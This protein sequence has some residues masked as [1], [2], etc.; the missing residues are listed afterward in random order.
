MKRALRNKKLI[1]MMVVG[2]VAVF[3][4]GNGLIAGTPLDTGY[5][6]VES[7][8]CQGQLADGALITAVEGERIEDCSAK[9]EVSLTTS[10]TLDQAQEGTNYAFWFEQTVIRWQEFRPTQT[11]LAKIDLYIDKNGNPGNLL[12]SVKDQ[13]EDVLWDAAVPQ[14]DIGESGWLEIPVDPSILLEPGSSYYI[15]VWSDADSPSP[16]QRCFWRGQTE[17]DY[18]RGISSQ[19]SGLPGYDFA[20]RTWTSLPSCVD[21]EDP[22]LGTEYYV[23]DTFADSGAVITVQSFQWSDGQWYDGGHTTVGNYGDAGGSG[24]EMWLNNVNLGFDFGDPWEGLSVLFGY[25]GGNLNIDINGDF[26][27]FNTFID[28]N[29][30]TIG[31]VNVVANDFG[32]GLGRLDL[33]GKVNSFAIGGQELAIDDVCPAVPRPVIYFADGNEIPGSVYRLENGMES[34]FYTRSSGR[35]HNLAFSPQGTLYYSNAND[36]DLYKLAGGETLVYHHDTYLGDVAFDSLGR[37]YFSEA[38]GAGGDGYIYRLDGETAFLYYTVELADVSFWGG[39]FTFDKDDNLYLSSGNLAGAKIYE[40]LD[41]IPG[42]VFSAPGQPITGIS[43][44]ADGSLFYAGWSG[45]DIYKVDLSAGERELFYSNP[46]HVHLSDVFV[47]GLPVEPKPDLIVESITGPASAVLG[48][49]LGDSLTLIIKN[50]GTA[51]AVGTGGY[52]NTDLV[53]SSDAVIGNGDDILLIGGRDQVFDVLASGQSLQVTLAGSN[54]IPEGMTTGLYYL[55]AIVDSFGSRVVESDEDNNTN[56]YYPIEIQSPAPLYLSLN[57]EDALEGIPVN[58]VV[59]DTDGPTY[60]TRLEIV[61][62]LS[63]W[64]SSAKDNIPVVLTIPDNIFGAPINTWVRD[65]NGGAL[66]AVS[67]DNLGDGQYR[68]TT[69]LSPFRTTFRKQI[70]WRFLIPNELPPQDVTVNAEIQVPCVDPFGTGTVRILAPGSVRTLIIAN[71]KLLYD[72]Y[73]EYQVT[74]LLQRLFTEAQGYPA[75][76]TPRAVIYYVE[77][78]D[79]RAYN[80]DNTAVDYTSEA[81]ANVAADAID[82]LIED[83]H[84]DAT[85]YVEIYIP[86]YGYAYLPIASPSFLLIVGDD[87]TI[88]FY[89]YDDPSNDEGINVRS[90]CPAAQGWCVDSA[91]NPAVH[92]TDED[93]I[94]TDNPYADLW[95]GTDWQTGS[96]ELYAGRLLGET[97]ADMLSLLE[98]GVSWDNGDRGGVVMASVDGWELG[99]EHDPG[100]AGHITD[101]YDVP[102]L[103]RGKG[104]VVRN[105]DIPAGEVQTIDVMSPY[106]GGSNSWNTNFRNAANSASG[107]DLFFIGGHD[108]YDHAVIPGDNFSPDDTC[109]GGTCDYNRFDDDHPIAMIVGCHGGLP[110][111]DGGG[112]NGGVDNDM[113]YDLVHEGVSAYIG[114][115]GF[116]YGSPSNLH[117]C[118]WAERLIQRFF[119]QLLMPSGGNSMALGAALAKA[120]SG[121]VFGYGGDDSLDR[122]TVT[123]FNLYGVPWTFIYYPSA[124]TATATGETGK[125]SFAAEAGAIALVDDGV[126]SRMFEVGIDSYDVATETQDDTDYDLFSIEGGDI[127]IADGAPILPYV[128]GYKMPLP[129]GATVTNVEVLDYT[130]SYIGTYNVPIALVAPWSEEGLRYTTETD[131]G[132]PYPAD[133]DLVQYQQNG[134]GLLFTIFPIQHNP[135]TDET[136]FYSHFEIQIT[137]ESPLAVVVTEFTTNK[138]QYVPGEEINTTADIANVGDVDAA[139]TATLTI[140][141]ALGETL[142]IETAG[143]FIVP[144]GGSHALPLALGGML[145]DGDY[146][147]EITVES[148]QAIVGGASTSISVIGGEITDLVVPEVLPLGE[149]GIFQVTFANYGDSTVTGEVTMTIQASDGG[150]T[151]ELAPQRI[152]VAGGSSETVMFAWI[153]ERV[154]C[155]DYDA[156]CAVA[157]DGQTYGPISRAFTVGFPLFLKAGWNMVSIPFEP[158]DNSTSAVFPGVAG[159]F[160]WGATSK[161]YY[162]PTIIVP[163][164]GYWVAVTEDT[165]IIVCGAPIET[166][167]TDIEA[168]WNMIGSVNAIASI[169]DPDDDPDGSVVPPAYWWDPMQRQYVTTYDVEPGKG[170]WVASLNDCTLTL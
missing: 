44:G 81:T 161:S 108:S 75:S 55:G 61:T 170:Y 159:V 127:A 62:K 26:R 93:Y 136:I 119:G 1:A 56:F 145:D 7:N 165:T 70:V 69:D 140:R 122:K 13:L 149:E 14:G 4:A 116:S 53:L 160:T 114:A 15:Y 143:E 124:T 65:T 87:D 150:F 10:Y 21:F 121:Y 71:R 67:Y 33:S 147:V 19:E 12:V 34:V 35:L 72:N 154:V 167:K 99:L 40:V 37:I 42:E 58:K 117:K 92:A 57:I 100:G 144:S 168:G 76:H 129:F 54:T 59:G 151:E 68:V 169:A 148:Q 6:A 50:I 137:Y 17:S 113:V 96:V 31:E 109:A 88:P 162:E 38:Y 86:S 49:A 83:W 107:M 74:N 125:Q 29:G 157:V 63:S 52:F 105:D 51:E 131:I 106:E 43:F 8:N 79:S 48:E 3:L 110:V 91:T 135:T 133:E 142:G 5:L 32:G 163:E 22:L 152:T 39:D 146:T 134:A 166:W 164:R 2:L 46:D 104:F 20:F 95:G 28:I 156:V 30:L 132:Y 102:A 77:R 158:I 103:F 45:G 25:Y 90:S 16:D 111:R 41:G 84:D 89:R 94:L 115:T 11:S 128:E 139:L 98:E 123:E 126:Y 47:V 120:K 82:D 138:D 101:L 85:K 23:K 64:S 97:A 141:D 112:I 153:A 80:W 27:N 130:S 60:H 118:T 9:V 73:T 155:G 66:T 78:Y 24:Q 18:D 36:Y